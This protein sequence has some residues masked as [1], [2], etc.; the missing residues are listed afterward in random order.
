MPSG[1]ISFTTDVS[2]ITITIETDSVIE[3]NETITVQ[4]GPVTG[5]EL[6]ATTNNTI[7]VNVMDNT[8]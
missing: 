4:F 2:C 1:T 8:S 7:M 6:S 5:A 3:I